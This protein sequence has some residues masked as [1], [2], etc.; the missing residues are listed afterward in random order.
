MEYHERLFAYI[1]DNLNEMD[2]SLERHSLLKLT[3]E[4]MDNKSISVKEIEPII[5]NLMK[6][7]SRHRWIHW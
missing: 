7:S 6:Q 1:C 5:N 4:E 3:Q 2:L